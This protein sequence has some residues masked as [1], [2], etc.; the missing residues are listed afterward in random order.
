MTNQMYIECVIATLIG[1]LI[2]IIVK[3]V[4]LNTDYKKANLQFSV[5]QYLKD[6][7]WVILLDIICCFALV[8]LVEEWLDLGDW[9][10]NKIKSIFVFVGFTGSYV[11]LYPLSVAKSKFRQAVDAKTNI[12]DKSTGDLSNPT[13][14]DEL[15]NK[16]KFK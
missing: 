16:F 7:K 8:Y 9:V 4:S 2:H 10:A 14:V 12:A 15:T 5:T 13:Q 11:V 6:D 3:I 1:M